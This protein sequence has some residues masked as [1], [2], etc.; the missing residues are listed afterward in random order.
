MPPVPVFTAAPITATKASGVTPQTASPSD[1]LDAASDSPAPTGTSRY[2]PS[3][4]PSSNPTPTRALSHDGPPPPQPGAVPRLPTATSEPPPPVPSGSTTQGQQ[5]APATTSAPYYPSLSQ[6]PQMGIPSPSQTYSQSQRGTATA[7]GP[8]PG[9]H[10][11]GY[12]Q[13]SALDQYQSAQ[14]QNDSYR[15]ANMGGGNAGQGDGEEGVWSSVVGWT[16]AAGKR[17]SEAE[18][19]VWKR[20]NKE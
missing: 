4:Q 11:S 10:P 20:I 17:L 15:N 5:Q 6:P 2:T 19:E 16:Q 9:T 7:T 8:G 14:A 18:S 1:S 13:N 3:N 12:Q